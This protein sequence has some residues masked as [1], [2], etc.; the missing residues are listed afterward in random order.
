MDAAGPLTTAALKPERTFQKKL[1]APAGRPGFGA[2]KQA[3]CVA[4]KKAILETLLQQP[5]YSA[6][7]A[8][9]AQTVIAGQTLKAHL[10]ASVRRAFEA[11]YQASRVPYPAVDVNG[12]RHLWGAGAKT[13]AW[14][15]DAVLEDGLTVAKSNVDTPPHDT[16]C[17]ERRVLVEALSQRAHPHAGHNDARMPSIRLMS[18]VQHQFENT[19][20]VRMTS[21]DVCLNAFRHAM[22]EGLMRPDTLVA[23]LERNPRGHNGLRLEV[24]TLGQL[25]PKTQQPLNSYS[26]RPLWQLPLVYSPTAKVLVEQHPALSQRRVR[27]VVQA[28]KS[29]YVQS[30]HFLLGHRVNE[31]TGVGVGMMPPLRP[32]RIGKGSHMY[33]QTTTRVRG[34]DVAAQ[35]AITQL[36]LLDGALKRAA[37]WVWRLYKAFGCQSWLANPHKKAGRGLRVVAYYSQ[38]NQ[39]LPNLVGL[40][41]LAKLSGEQNFLVATVQPNAIAVDA[42]SDYL[43]LRYTKRNHLE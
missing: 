12:K 7:A 36:G 18:L 23:F 16:H 39:R 19:N 30:Q 17:A 28:A 42:L 27:R 1:A 9:A 10:A 14:G 31:H 5:I 22:A 11:A 24:K 40:G 21:C 4:E 26:T 20:T 25:L 38:E 35:Q 41:R 15:A 6:E 43:P 2:K 33:H 3:L 8:R 13:G 34:E 37:T 32:W 29:A